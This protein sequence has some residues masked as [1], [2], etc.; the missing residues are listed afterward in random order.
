MGQ[1]AADTRG[2]TFEGVHIPKENILIGERAGFKNAMGPFDETRSP[3]SI[4][5]NLYK[6][7]AA[8]GI[9]ACRY[10][11]RCRSIPFS[12]DEGNRQWYLKY[13][14]K[15]FS[16]DIA[17]K[18]ATDA[19]QIFGGN[20]FTSEYPVEKLMRDAKIF[21]IYEGTAQIQRLIISRVITDRAKNLKL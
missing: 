4:I 8:C 10:G 13:L 3:V 18:C 2:R 7:V 20:G 16:A 21:Q 1:R 6:Q 5:L 11:H 17:N 14:S 9:Y 15:C 19:V 12:L